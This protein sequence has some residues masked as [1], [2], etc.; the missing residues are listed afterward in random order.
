M[1]EGTW[2]KLEPVY[3]YAQR[4]KT[5]KLTALS[6]FEKQVKEEKLISQKASGKVQPEM[7]LNQK[8]SK[9]LQE[10]NSKKMQNFKE[11]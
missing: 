10:L 9:L 11:K 2:K 5:F 7:S 4:P 1:I 6:I 8:V 3:Q